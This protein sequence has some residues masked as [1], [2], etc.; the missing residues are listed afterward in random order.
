MPIITR[1]RQC[2]A[3]FYLYCK[4]A[5][6]PILS[7]KI[8]LFPPPLSY[9]LKTRICPSYFHNLSVLS[10]LPNVLPFLILAFQRLHSP[11]PFKRHSSIVQTQFKP[12]Q[13]KPPTRAKAV[14]T[15]GLPHG[16]K[17]A[18]DANLQPKELNVTQT[19]APVHTLKSKPKLN[20]CKRFVLRRHFSQQ[21]LTC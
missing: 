9:S 21:H 10:V 16:H 11:T 15:K 20:S 1:F 19:C 18:V 2:P 6:S 3:T 7:L 12:S 5:V 17:K 4:W 8:I 13:Q 14:Q